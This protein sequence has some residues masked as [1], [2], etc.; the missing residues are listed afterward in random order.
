MRALKKQRIAEGRAIVASLTAELGEQPEQPR[1]PTNHEATT[2][3]ALELWES[4]PGLEWDEAWDFA[5]AFD[6]V[7]E[8]L[9]WVEDHWPP[10][11][12]AEAARC[13]KTPTNAR[14]KL[15]ERGLTR[16]DFEDFHQYFI[17]FPF[18]DDEW[19]ATRERVLRLLELTRDGVEQAGTPTVAPRQLDLFRAEQ[20]GSSS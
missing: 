19:T 4:A 1:S 14:A 15:A 13:W 2:R 7:G 8:V 11:E 10:R 16:Q 3:R 12:A 20:A 9:S 5:T 18:A 6:S 17:A